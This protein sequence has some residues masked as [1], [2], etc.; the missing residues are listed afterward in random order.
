[1]EQIGNWMA[2]LSYR[3]QANFIIWRMFHQ[4][5]TN[6]LNMGGQQLEESIF[7]KIAGP[8]SNETQI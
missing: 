3:D 5:S 6:F 4:F 2:S 1:M 8:F 7:E